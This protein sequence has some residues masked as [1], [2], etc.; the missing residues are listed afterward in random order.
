LEKAARKSNSRIFT[1][2]NKKWRKWSERWRN[3]RRATLLPFFHG[4]VLL[5]LHTEVKKENGSYKSN[6][7]DLGIPAD[8]VQMT[9]KGKLVALFG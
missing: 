6:C 7:G 9:L 8:V 2:S 3:S 4:G 1:S 5:A